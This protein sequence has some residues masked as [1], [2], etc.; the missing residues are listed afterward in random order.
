M[1][2]LLVLSAFQSHKTMES[3]RTRE[4]NVESKIKSKVVEKN[5]EKMHA[6]DNKG[7]K[8]EEEMKDR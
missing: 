1:N 8:R 6:D 3:T 4:K 7:R 2:A 5:K